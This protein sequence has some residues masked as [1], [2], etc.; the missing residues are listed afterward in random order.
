MKASP[1]RVWQPE[2]LQDEPQACT[3]AQRPKPHGPGRGKDSQSSRPPGGQPGPSAR[4][5]AAVIHRKC[6]DCSGGSRKEA[7]R[8]KLSDC[9]LWAHRPQPAQAKLSTSIE[10]GD[11]VNA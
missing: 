10:G 4:A 1:L 7:E 6:M 3:H 5:L 9:P 8:C 11:H 2:D